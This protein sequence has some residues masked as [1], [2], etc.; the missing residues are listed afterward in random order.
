MEHEQGGG[1]DEETDDAGFG[2]GAGVAGGGDCDG[3][4]DG[5]VGNAL[6]KREGLGDGLQLGEDFS[7]RLVNRDKG[8]VFGEQVVSEA[9]VG[10]G[11]DVF[12]IAVEHG[13]GA[14]G[15]DAI[16]SPQGTQ[17]GIVGAFAGFGC[18]IK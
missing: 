12:R 13:F 8:G 17:G 2:N 18:D 10:D 11:F 5:L 6:R 7:G 4:A 3:G 1:D 9:E 14:K 16:E 15:A